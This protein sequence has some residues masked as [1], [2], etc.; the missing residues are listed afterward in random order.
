MPIAA[1]APVFVGRAIAALHRKTIVAHAKDT[2]KIVI[3]NVS[4]AVFFLVP[5]AWQAG[6]PLFTALFSALFLGQ[7]FTLPVYA[8]L[9][10]VVGGVA[11]ASLKELSF[12]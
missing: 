5:S 4:V 8:A 9:L 6:E 3:S 7:I 12:T 10:P 11:I 2:L 1:V